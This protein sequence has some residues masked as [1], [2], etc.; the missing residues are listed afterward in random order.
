MKYFENYPRATQ[1]HEV[2]SYHWKN[3]ASRLA[4]HRVATNL[5]FIKDTPSM[6][7]KKAKQSAVK[8]SM[9]VLY[10]VEYFGIQ[11]SNRVNSPLIQ[12]GH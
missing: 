8:G 1:T 7:Y 5:Q 6:N 2:S 10:S 3:G 9:P 12:A 11:F 4:S